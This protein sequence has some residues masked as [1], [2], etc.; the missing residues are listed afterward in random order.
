[1]A[2]TNDRINELDHHTLKLKPM[3]VYNACDVIFH[4]PN[5]VM[6]VISE[7]LEINDLFPH[8]S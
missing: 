5:L 1:M 8:K 6:L 2:A 4:A 3:F 7:G